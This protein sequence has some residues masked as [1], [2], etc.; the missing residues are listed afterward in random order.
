MTS[1][2]LVGVYESLQETWGF[3]P[4]FCLHDTHTHAQ[5]N[6]IKLNAGNFMFPSIAFQK[7]A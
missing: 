4:R 1:I 2:T 6:K 7:K 5:K 3:T